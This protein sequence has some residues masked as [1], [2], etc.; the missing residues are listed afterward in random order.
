[1]EAILPE[2]RE[3]ICNVYTALTK[4]P[5]RFTRALRGVSRLGPVNQPSMKTSANRPLA[6]RAALGLACLHL[7]ASAA[8]ADPLLSSWQVSNSRR[9]ARVYETTAEQAAGTPV[10]TWPNASLTSD[11]G[12]QSTVAYSDVQRVS[13]SANYVYVYST[14][15]ASYTMGPWFL[16]AA[17]TVLFPNWPSASGDLMRFPRSPSVAGTKTATGLGPIGLGVNG[18]AIFNGNDAFSYSN[19]S[20]QDSPMGSGIWNRDALVNEGPSFDPANAHQPPSGQY[21]YHVNPIGLRY[22]LGDHVTYTASSNTYAEATSSPTHSP[23]LGWAYDGFPIYGPYG[24]SSPLSAGSGV[25]LMKSGFAKRNG[26][27]GT[28]NLATSG[29]VS[30][31]QWAAAAQGRSATLSAG[32]QGPAVSTARPIGY[33]MED[34]AYLGDLGKVQGV[35]FDL[36]Q[37]NA[38]YCVTPDYPNGTYAYFVT[39]DG[40]ATPV[41]PYLVGPQYL[42]TVGGGSVSSVGESVTD[43]VRGGQAS[44]LSVT[45]Y[46][47]GGSVTVTWPSVEGGTYRVDT[48]PDG[49]AWTVLAAAVTSSG[50]ATKSYSTQTVAAYY[51]VTLTALAA[52]STAGTGGISGIGNTAGAQAPVGSS[53]TAALVNIS[54]RVSC[55]G[56]AGT[57]IPGFALGGSG[58]KPMLVRGVGPGLAAGF[59][60]AGALAD[61]SVNLTTSS[62]TVLASNSAWLAA[63]AATM[64][65]V[66]AFALPGGSAD[67]AIVVSLPA[68]SYT[69]PVTSVSGGSGVVLIEAY[70]ASL[71]AAGP[72]LVNASARGYVGTGTGVMI[73]GFVI[74][75]SGTQELLIRAVGPTLAAHGLTSGL[76]AQPTLT[77]Y[78]GDTEL[79]SDANWGGASNAA[80]IASAAAQV[81]AFSLPAGS[82]DGALLVTLPPGAYSAEVSGVAGTTGTALV[83]LYAIP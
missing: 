47:L 34:N 73:A 64:A 66:G 4:I 10:T 63:D 56:S 48:S 58:T 37:Y 62:G 41:F 44:A 70:D 18:V 40:S 5:G 9:Y 55:G 24:Y 6:P 27:N 74:T 8:L 39:L 38:R 31:P 1:M 15:V 35:D 52:Y 29:R 60:L 65:A 19:G 30:L 26:A 49:S 80:Q 25:R 13:Y 11:G 83:E 78:Q 72:A 3:E 22:Q 16:D 57:P 33:Y 67:A 82:S 76:L 61:P 53:G 50:G 46:N 32:Q 7:I 42:G 68:G 12:G 51:R 36:N 21:H 17:K 20:G 79:A 69:A 75:G 54:A 71:G 23:I 45:A 43:Y 81:G 77:L 2:R 28:D 14:G 59:G